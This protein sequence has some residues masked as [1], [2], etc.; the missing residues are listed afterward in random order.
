[1]GWI[2]RIG[3]PMIRFEVTVRYSYPRP[4]T[5]FEEAILRL[6]RDFS[7]QPA[8]RGM[9]LQEIFEQ[10][11]GVPDADQVVLPVVQELFDIGALLC[12][13]QLGSMQ[14]I[15]L[16]DLE[17]SESGKKFL[18]QGKLAAV[19]NERTETV[20]YD[21][22]LEQ[23]QQDGPVETTRP[24]AHVP[25]PETA[26][27][28]P[29]AR[30]RQWYERKPPAW[31]PDGAE[32][33]SCSGK[34]LGI[35]WASRTATLGW[36]NETLA[37]DCGD[38]KRTHYVESLSKSLAERHLFTPLLMYGSNLRESS[39]SFPA[40]SRQSVPPD[41]PETILPLHEARQAL[42][43]QGPYVLV[44]AQQVG[45]AP[46]SL[47]ARCVIQLGTQAAEP[48][49]SQTGNQTV[50]SWSKLPEE[51]GWL[52]AGPTLTVWGRIVDFRIARGRMRAPL[53]VL[54]EHQALPEELAGLL[55][56]LADALMKTEH[57]ALPALWLEPENYQKQLQ[58][59]F[60]EADRDRPEQLVQR[61]GSV[62]DGLAALGRQAKPYALGDL[63]VRLVLEAQAPPTP[64]ILAKVKR[65]LVKHPL[66]D[67]QV[68]IRWRAVLDAAAVPKTGSPSGPQPEKPPS[69]SRSASAG[70]VSP[71]KTS[72]PR[73]QT[74]PRNSGPGSRSKR[75]KRNRK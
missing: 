34:F 31:L 73:K 6:V 9:T 37:L 68:A 11:L 40:P 27:V 64:G 10:I 70:Q 18:R 47:G 26:S 3:F 44:N 39:P 71:R 65:F 52:G 30:F 61:I 28:F 29:E 69:D 8:Y 23:F 19:T 5:I 1:M 42:A 45:W 67:E 60:A 55:K 33:V 36:R 41:G 16:A 57:A 54:V 7:R 13:R 59:A 56:R 38:P 17:L 4:L 74:G 53:G 58:A 24:E 50:I 63:L 15:T 22:V 46:G 49:V 75:N 2:R 25:E 72:S 66:Q 51:D 32:V 43:S 20:Y 35:R 14:Q 21:P 48:E 62:A 12:R